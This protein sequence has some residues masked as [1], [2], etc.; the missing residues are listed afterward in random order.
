MF[1]HIGGNVVIPTRDI[2]G[3]FDIAS[4]QNPATQEFMETAREEGFVIDLLPGEKKSFVLANEKIYLSPIASN[5]LR[6]RWKIDL[7]RY[8]STPEQHGQHQ[9]EGE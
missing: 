1:L 7:S 9:R 2:I 8:A 3:I 6:K 4:I 5:T